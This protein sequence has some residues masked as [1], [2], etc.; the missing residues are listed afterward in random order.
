MRRVFDCFTFFNEIELL[1]IRF[2]ELN[3]VVDFF[4]IAEASVTFQGQQKPLFF[5]DNRAQFEQYGHKIIHLVVD[6]LPNSPNPWDREFAQRDALDLG[7]SAAEPDDLILISDIDEI[8]R[9]EAIS[10]AK[11]LDGYLAFDMPMFQY[12]LNLRAE[13]SGWNRAFGYSRKDRHRLKN[14]TSG[15]IDK[16]LLKEAFGDRY[17]EI[18][19]AGWHFTYLGGAERIRTKLRSFSHTEEWFTTMITEGGI[20]AQ[21]QDG[22]VVGNFWHL[23]EYVPIDGTFP[24]AVRREEQYFR[25]CDFIKDIYQAH[26]ELQLRNRDIKVRLKAEI[27]RRSQVAVASRLRKSNNFSKIIS[28]G[29][30][31]AAAA[32]LKAAGLRDAAYPFDWLF[33]NPSLVAD[34]IEDGFKIFMNQEYL[35]PIDNGTKCRHEF[36]QS[37]YPMGSAAVFNHHNPSCEPHRSHFQRAITRFNTVIYS[38]RSPVLLFMMFNEKSFGTQ[39][40]HDFQRIEQATNGAAVFVLI[41][42][43]SYSEPRGYVKI[44]NH[45][46]GI[47]VAQISVY[48]NIL[49]GMLFEDKADSSAVVDFL[50]LIFKGFV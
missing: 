5:Q 14:L 9:S 44:L 23:A 37:R 22:G 27:A 46:G 15:R 17:H 21:V 8:F 25:R 7:C 34:C 2:E 18:G 11:M 12:F 28:I 19:N 40:Y 36:Y 4:V 20:E 49:D 26:R 6:G 3:D 16:N 48:S 13:P 31:C 1:K 24:A 35:N 45:Q 29:T 30:F 41:V 38:L 50:K 39:Y 43:Q 42:A 47:T 33:T 32:H 10:Q